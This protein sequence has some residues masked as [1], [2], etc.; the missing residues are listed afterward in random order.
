MAAP[1]PGYK[2]RISGFDND[3]FVVQDGKLWSWGYNR[4]GALGLNESGPAAKKSSPTQVGTEETWSKN[5]HN[6]V[7]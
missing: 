6:A 1:S 5:I 2:S 3:R 7:Q 4:F